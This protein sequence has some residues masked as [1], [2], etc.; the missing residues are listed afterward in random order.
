M[1]IHFKRCKP[2]RKEYVA[3]AVSRVATTASCLESTWFILRHAN[4][5]YDVI[6][7]GIFD[8]A[9]AQIYLINSMVKQRS[10]VKAQNDW[11]STKCLFA[12]IFD[13]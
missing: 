6:Y 3:D 1:G 5:I 4:P 12:C 2:R 9:F 7:D 11:S 8:V 13:H 10:L